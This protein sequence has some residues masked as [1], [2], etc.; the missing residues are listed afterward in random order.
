MIFHINA[1][2][3][4]VLSI[5]L[6]KNCSLIS[7]DAANASEGDGGISQCGL[8][9]LAKEN[10]DAELE[11][12]IATDKKF[13]DNTGAATSGDT[14]PIFD[15]VRYSNIFLIFFDFISSD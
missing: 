8:D 3:T 2:I 11:I 5:Y 9:K 6:M 14:G 4:F 7:D 12:L 1:L 10:L 15:V 13:R